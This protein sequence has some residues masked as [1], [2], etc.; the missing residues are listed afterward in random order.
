MQVLFSDTVYAV[1]L[2]FDRL[3]VGHK[4]TLYAKSHNSELHFDLIMPLFGLRILVKPLHASW[5]NLCVQGLFSDTVC[6]AALK[7]H[8]LIQG[9]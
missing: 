1:A 9:N 7:L 2:K 6:A 8:K 4:M 3:I 5:L